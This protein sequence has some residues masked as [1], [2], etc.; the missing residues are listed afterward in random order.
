VG[1]VGRRAHLALGAIR[2]FNGVSALVVPEI[3]S[4]R[5]GSDPAASPGAIYPLRMFGVRTVILGA[6]LL[7]G[8]EDT[9]QRSLALGRFVHAS[10]TAAVA[11]GGLRGQ[12]PPRTA[13]LLTG[14]SALNTTLA[15]LGTAAHR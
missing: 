2:L 10:D 3:V 12:L 4:R 11:L 6:E 15:V 14:V 1:A 13:V 8:D 5:L 7:F 9:R